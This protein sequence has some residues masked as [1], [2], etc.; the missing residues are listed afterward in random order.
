MKTSIM[1]VPENSPSPYTNDFYLISNI[2]VLVFVTCVHVVL[3]WNI[4]IVFIYKNNAFLVR[5][6]LFASWFVLELG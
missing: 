3:L 6:L 2:Y 5:K 4:S 1:M